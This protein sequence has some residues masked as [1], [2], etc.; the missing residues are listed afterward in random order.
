MKQ[1]I[2][3]KQLVSDVQS[4][5]MARNLPDGC[6]AADQALK[7]NS[8]NGE[9]SDNIVKGAPLRPSEEGEKNIRDDIGD[10]LVVMIVNSLQTGIDFYH[11]YAMA[12]QHYNL[13][14]TTFI[15]DETKDLKLRAYA[16]YNFSLSKYILDVVFEQ[17]KIITELNLYRALVELI[18]LS[19]VFGI[20]HEECL[21]ES[22]LEIKDRKGVMFGG[23]FIKESDHRYKK[24]IEEIERNLV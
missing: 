19:Q 23:A 20:Q 13:A 4:W 11:V 24:A 10:N 7:L 6:K 22:Y 2:I 12:L 16:Q 15:F 1:N 5:A 3:S 9:L 18:Y 8:E 17:N 21:R 14:F